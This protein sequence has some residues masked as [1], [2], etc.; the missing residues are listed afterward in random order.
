MK[1]KAV[2]DAV[3]WAF[4]RGWR[5]PT[6]LWLVAANLVPLAGVLVLDWR[7][8]EVMLLF[9][10]ESAIIGFVSILKMARGA[11]LAALFLVPFFTFHYGGFMVVHLVFIGAV[12]IRSFAGFWDALV[13]VGPAFLALCISHGYSFFYALRRREFEGAKPHDPMLGAYKRIAVMHVTI[14]L[15][16]LPTLALDEPWPAVALLVVLKIAVD[17]ASHLY[18]HRAKE[19]DIPTFSPAPPAPT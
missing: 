14:I 1:T 5:R 3:D 18:E 16:A 10:S 13:A 8:G 11:G 15:G 7:L 9:W 19:M 4:L 17:V 12:F 6:L 2:P